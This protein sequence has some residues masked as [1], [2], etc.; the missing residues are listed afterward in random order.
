MA[1]T[2]SLP[3]DRRLAAD[4]LAGSR[5]HVRG[6]A[7][8]GVLEKGESAVLL[9]GA[10]PG[11][12]RAELGDLRLPGRRRGHPHRG[13]A[14]GDRARRRRRGQD[15]HRPEPQ[16][17][18]RHRPAALRPARAAQRRPRQVIELQDT[19]LHRAVE[20]GDA[21]LPG[22]THLQRAQPV[23]LTHHLLAHGWALARDLD[24]VLH[25]VVRMDVS[26]LGAGALAGSSLPLDPDGVADDL[27]FGEPV[28]ELARRRVATATSWPR[29]C[30]TW[31]CW[32][33]TCRAWARSSCCG[34]ARSSA[35]S[36]STTPT[37]R[38]ARCSRRRRT[39]T[40]P[41]WPGPRRAGS[42]GTWRGCWPRSRV[43]RWR[44]TGTSR[45]TRSRCSTPST[46]SR[47]ALPA[48]MGMLGDRALRHREDA[49]ARRTAPPPPRSTWPSGSWSGGCRSAR[50]TRWSG[51]SCATRCSAASHWPSSSR[52]TRIWATDALGLLEPGVAVTRRTSPGG[53]GP[54]PVAVQVERFATASTSTASG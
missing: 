6:L 11:R 46:R 29:R 33:S 14:P 5:A 7:G 21:Y 2:A 32:A 43:C 20:A 25:S 34:R 23:L 48:M 44:T 22:Y 3:Y 50:R 19:L 18:G 12:G 10:E 17:P 1:F 31:P 15:P 4:D 51:R 42:S 38:G 49:H 53:A 47:R 45:R 28:R 54:K 16:R 37:P 30:S 52:P 35:S 41:S 9:D 8:P 40:W 26:P 24:R 39:P 36:S 13:G 27:G